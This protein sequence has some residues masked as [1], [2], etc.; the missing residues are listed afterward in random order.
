MGILPRA[1]IFAFLFLAT[2]VIHAQQ[3]QEQQADED[4][5]RCYA[6]EEDPYVLF[7]TKTSYLEVDNENVDPVILPGCEAKSFWLVA[8]HGTRNPGKKAIKKIKKHVPRLRD[9]IVE[10]FENGKGEKNVLH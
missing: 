7:S 8:R 3:Q 5:D 1:S 9:K 4:A 2:R 10:N 6:N